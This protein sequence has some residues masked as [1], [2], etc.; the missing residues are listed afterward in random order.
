MANK[1]TDIPNIVGSQH[2]HLNRVNS[3][4]KYA[5]DMV[6]KSKPMEGIVISA[7]FQYEGRGQIGRFW[8]SEE[9]KNITCSTILRPS[10]LEARDQFQL[11]IAISLAISEVIQYF[12]T[13]KDVHIKWPNDIYVEDRKI[14]GIL[15]Q[16]TLKGK[17]IDTTIVGTGININQTVFSAD[18]PNPTSL[19]IELGREIALDEVYERLFL[20]L[21]HYYHRLKHRDNAFIDTYLEQLYRKDI[22]SSFILE[23][24][25]HLTGVIK[26][27]DPTGQLIVSANGQENRYGF[28]ELKL[29][30]PN[31]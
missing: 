3:T 30:I 2:I 10:F 12:I 7:A 24:G 18:I 17:I 25:T 27:V 14:A 29:Q 13:T 22:V 23:D 8:E 28:R 20:A 26:G 15:I 9:G 31:G 6:S 5:N 1:Y 11:N 16:N 19:A 21:N 4:N